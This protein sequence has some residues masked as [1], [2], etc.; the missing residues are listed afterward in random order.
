MT[1]ESWISILMLIPS[2]EQ[3]SAPTLK[4]KKTAGTWKGAAIRLSLIIVG[5]K[6]GVTV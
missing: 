4:K 5:K 1:E 2:K 6:M 3:S